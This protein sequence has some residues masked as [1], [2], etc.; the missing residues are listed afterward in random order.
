MSIEIDSRADAM[1]RV[2]QR[3]LMAV[4]KLSIVEYAQGEAT[5]TQTISG[6]TSMFNTATNSRICINVV[7][8]PVLNDGDASDDEID[9]Q[10]APTPKLVHQPEK[11]QPYHILIRSEEP[12]SILQMP[13][14]E[15]KDPE[16]RELKLALD[17]LTTEL[18]VANDMTN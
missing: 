2:V 17:N 4:N 1:K 15:I 16:T 10:I 6:S 18:K 11:Q 5:F 12:K 14:V 7:A 3:F 8:H 13:A 9:M